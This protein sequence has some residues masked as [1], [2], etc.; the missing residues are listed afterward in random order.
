M[1][2][3]TLIVVAGGKG[4][5]MGKEIPKQFLPLSGRP[6]LMRTIDLFFAYDR[7]MDIFVGLPRE[8]T[9]YWG[10]LCHKE[11]FNIKHRITPAGE[12]RFHTVRNALGEATPGS[13]VAIHDAVRPLVSQDTIG[14]C[15][16]K[17]LLTGAAIPCIRVPESLRQSVRGKSIPVDREMFRLVQTPQVFHHDIIMR[18][19]KQDYEDS[20]TDDAG[21]VEKSGHA[22]SLVEGNP[23]NIKITK[24]QDLACA[25]ALLSG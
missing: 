2:R 5:R 20:F 19:Y 16:E 23:E 14:R 8:Y 7:D 9:S 25:E 15:F 24:P 17:A 1:I 18:A 6:V 10:E 13:L 12:T 3:K 11:G 21:V 4:S 22:V